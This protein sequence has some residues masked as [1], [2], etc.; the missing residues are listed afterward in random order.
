MSAVWDHFRSRLRHKLTHLGE[1]EN[2]TPSA[3]AGSHVTRRK[4]LRSGRPASRPLHL[5]EPGS[6][7]S[8]GEGGMGSY[9]TLLIN[10]LISS[11]IAFG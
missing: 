9:R 8:G 11:A 10:R 1:T 5:H 6:V 7:T 2:I 4:T 3:C